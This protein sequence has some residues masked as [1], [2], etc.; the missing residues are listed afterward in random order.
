MQNLGFKVFAPEDRNNFHEI[1]GCA[2]L[3]TKEVSIPILFQASFLP[4]LME[5]FRFSLRCKTESELQYS[6]LLLDIYA[7]VKMWVNP[8]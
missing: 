1:E 7:V 2:M 3:N 5:E 4:S 6:S 8:Q